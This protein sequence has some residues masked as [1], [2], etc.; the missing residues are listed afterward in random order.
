MLNSQLLPTDCWRAL[1]YMNKIAIVVA[2]RTP[3]G[4]FQGQLAALSAP[5]LGA[6]AIKS[7]VAEATVPAEDI[8][9]LL[10]GC[11]L[12]AGLGQAPARQAGLGAGLPAGVRC[13]T[14]NKVCGSGMKTVMLGCDA[15]TAGSAEVV[16]TGG[17][18]SMSNAPYLLPG[19]RSGYRMGHQQ[20]LDHMFY[21]GLQNPYDQKMMGHFAEL[22]ADQRAFTRA[23][24]DALAQRSV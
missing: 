12:S 1:F 3:I 14:V 10:M 6:V 4:S 16:V 8:D 19:A 9:E 11:V 21:D 5:E 18:E 13:T 20:T 15:I 24:Q 17:M 2:K 22:C 23:Q 7:A